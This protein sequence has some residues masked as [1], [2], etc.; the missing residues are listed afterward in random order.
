MK[1]EIKPNI[2]ME[3][4]KIIPI[5]PNFFIFIFILGVLSEINQEMAT[6]NYNVMKVTL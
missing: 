1:T 6:A 3:S 2:N 5:F 4:V